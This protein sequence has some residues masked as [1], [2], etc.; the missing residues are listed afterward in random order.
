MPP[1]YLGKGRGDPGLVGSGALPAGPVQPRQERGPTMLLLSPRSALLSVYCPQ[2][3][4][5]L[6]SGSY[7]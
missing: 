4:L 2:I 5:I 7:L 1:P 6:S 3:F